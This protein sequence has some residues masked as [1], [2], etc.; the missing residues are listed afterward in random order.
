[1]IRG[2]R[3]TIALGARLTE[4]AHPDSPA[5]QAKLDARPSSLLEHV[6]RAT[7]YIDYLN[8]EEGGETTEESGAANV[9]EMVRVAERF[10]TA[11]ELL[12]YIDETITEGRAQRDDKQAGGVRVLLMSIHRSKGLEW[13]HVYVVGL[14]EMVLPHAKGDPEEE[15]RLAYV[16]VTRA[17]DVLTLSYVRRIATRAGI[18]DVEPSRF[19]LDTGL[20]LDLPDHPADLDA[21]ELEANRA[22]A[23]TISAPTA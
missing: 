4:E 21:A 2:M 1:M 5:G 22:R 9:R 13:P 7:K 11:D 16:A 15:R 23:R 6:V 17:R 12:S 3:E 8:K 19:L 10:A 14:N 18:R 20:P